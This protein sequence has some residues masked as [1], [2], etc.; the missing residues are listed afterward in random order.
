MI[1]DDMELVREY[2]RGNS[3]E[4]FATLVSRHVDLVYSVALRQVR[5]SHL[6][7]EIAQVVFIL[8]ARKAASLG[9]KTILPGWLC[10][11]A[12]FTSD[13]ALTIQRRRQHR[14]QEAYMQSRLTEPEP[15]NWTQIA[16]LLDAAMS[17][18]GE[19]DHDA[20]VL[21]FFYNRSFKDVGRAFGASEDA[22]KKRVNRALE[23]LRAFFTKRGVA[24][25]AAII[26]GAIS[27]NS[28][29]AAPLTLAQSA[30]TAAMAKGAV[31]SGSTLTLIQGALKIMA[32]T[33][34]KTAIVV[35]AGLLL[36]AGTATVGIKE[37]H[38]HHYPWREARVE[39]RTLTDTPP[40]VK[41]LPSKF[42]QKHGLAI[43]RQDR[44]IGI[45]VLMPDLM[46]VAY[47]N[48]WA[49]IVSPPDLAQRRV[50][51]IANLPSGSREALRSQVEEQF[52]V[53][54]HNETRQVD[55]L[56]LRVARRNAP[57]LKS[58][59]VHNGSDYNFGRL[60]FMGQP[61]SELVNMLEQYFQIP[62][63][64]RTGLTGEWDFTVTWNEAPDRRNPDGLKQAILDKIGLE[65]VPGHEEVEMLVLEQTR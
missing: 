21:R 5:D 6:A 64:D 41:I 19:R 53:K 52:K 11:A 22:A 49:R 58:T 46:Q 7:E 26:A 16:P 14:E 54:G 39:M 60:A 27:A 48:S 30:T 42:N 28:V 62:V 55:V 61:M 32:W 34:A 56:Q 47:S 45:G 35:G 29:H 31:A 4:A 20:I 65:L 1:T 40:Q 43:D 33:K 51:F 9:P 18:L 12:R 63:I 50:D 37:V 24:S 13:N 59:T 8:L 2:V 38:K 17:E 36:A 44:T 15:E 25:T 3:E 10:R 23:K 57:G